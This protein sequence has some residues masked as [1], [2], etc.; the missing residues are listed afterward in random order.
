MA[1]KNLPKVAYFCMEYGLDTS[2]RTY[3]GGLGILA[4][5]YLKGAKDYDY[6]IVGIGIKW[7]QGYTD[8]KI[9]EDGRPYDTYHNYKYDFLKDTGVK[10]TVKIRQRDVVCKVWEVTEFGNAPI[11]LLD[12]DLPENEDAWITGQLYGW[13]GEERIAQEMVLGIG[14]VRALRALGIDVDVYHFNEGHALFAGFELIKEKMD[15]GMSFEEAVKA[16]R[17]EIVFTTHTPIVQ[18]NESHYLDRLMYMGAN[19]GLTLEQLVSI[20]GSPFNMTVGAL[21]LSRISNA[22]ADLHKETAN[23]MW[24]HIDNRAEIIGITN[25]IH[26]P[27]WVDERMIDCAVNGGDLWEIHMDNKK[28]LINF[29][30]ERN[31]VRLDANKLLIGFSRRAA[32]YKRSNFIF[33]DEKVIDPLLKEGKI[34]IVFSGKAH[35]LDDTGK[36]IVENIV[37][38]SKKYP[39]SVVFLENYDMTIGAMLT[40]GSD[41][42]LNNP[43]RPKEASGTSGMKAAMNGVLNVSTL[44][45]WWPEAC[46]HGVN[47]WQFGDGFES[48]DEKELDAH[49]LKALYKILLDEVIPTYYENRD[50]WVEMMR[51]SILST[52]DQFSIKRMLEEYYEK[53]YIKH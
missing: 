48:E 6:P 28:K 36:E 33:T 18:G 3:A 43:R 49:D 5:D 38:M 46:N 19:N 20:G 35:P 16:S 45:G 27:T 11:Y 42:W 51:N 40:R 30:E 12:T 24:A 34:Q 26:I 9:D 41:V 17:E 21:R 14:G 37:R 22:V 1:N 10:V 4:G 50:K 52:K 13:F 7:K 31:G 25:A 32:P 8:Q 47:G 15:R 23:K 53:L 39:N 29:V 44:D 2:L